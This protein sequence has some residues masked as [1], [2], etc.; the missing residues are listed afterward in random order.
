MMTIDIINSPKVQ[1][2]AIIPKITNPSRSINQTKQD[3]LKT[4]ETIGSQH[5]KP[6]AKVDV[7]KVKST[8]SSSKSYVTVRKQTSANNTQP[9]VIVDTYASF[10]KKKYAERI[11]TRFDLLG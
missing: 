10:R 9:K 5:V 1:K 2:V 6:I 7:N 4:A 11:K 3:S 8:Y